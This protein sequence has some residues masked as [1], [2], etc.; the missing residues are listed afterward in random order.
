[1]GKFFLLFSVFLSISFNTKILKILKDALIITAPES[2]AGTIPFLKTWMLI[3]F[4]LA[5]IYLYGRLSLFLDR[6]KIFYCFTSGFLFFFAFFT[7]VLFPS[8]EFLHPHALC[9]VLEVFLPPGWKGF[10]STFRYWTFSLFYVIAEMWPTILL[11]FLF[12]NFV[13]SNVTE[14]EAKR[15]YGLFSLD[16][17]G[18]VAGVITL[19]LADLDIDFLFSD[20]WH[21]Y[22]TAMISVVLLAGF[23]QM[24]CYFLYHRLYCISSEESNSDDSRYLSKMSMK[25]KFQ[26]IY[27]SPS[28]FYVAVAVF[29]FEFTDLLI[30]VL[31]KDQV[32][33]VYKTPWEFSEYM[34][35]VTWI[36]GVVGV[37][38][39]LGLSGFVLRT[40]P[41]VTAG[42]ITPCILL[43]TSGLFFSVLFFPSFA[44]YLATL[45]SCE[46]VV[47]AVT[48]GSLRSVLM[49][50]AKYTFFD[51]SKEL[52]F[53]QL[54]SKQR[55]NGKALSDAFAS[56][57]GKSASSLSHQSLLM[58]FHSL[59][60]A[61]PVIAFLVFASSLAWLRSIW[62]L[63]KVFSLP[64]KREKEEQRRA[65]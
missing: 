4:S 47:V 59:L 57:L 1:M 50:V 17:G 42:L 35:Q 16:I 33:L 32:S 31:W 46:P 51:N 65:S 22:M 37:L 43:L 24:F 56:R 62:S 41:W 38:V 60:V 10:V 14:H 25:E 36:T 18:L 63:G 7:L 23:F 61:A 9:D 55:L 44:N 13:A 12:W 49:Q 11:S 15:F 6:E 3:P 54:S 52:A 39:V 27:E 20:H 45:F 2:G 34:A 40:K 8:K 30:E 21:G 28:L 48:V 64:M 53:L 58:S 29:S 5:L 19:Y 26:S